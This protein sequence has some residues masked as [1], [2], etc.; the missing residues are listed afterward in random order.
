M[1]QMIYFSSQ[2]R[3]EITHTPLIYPLSHLLSPPLL[4][5]LRLMPPRQLTHPVVN[6]LRNDARDGAFI[7]CSGV[8]RLE[9]GAVDVAEGVEGALEGVVF[10]A[11]EVVAVVCVVGSILLLLATLFPNSPVHHHT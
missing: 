7:H 8:L 4:H 1:L 2:C 10:P 11:E 6:L 5:I 3:P 9:G